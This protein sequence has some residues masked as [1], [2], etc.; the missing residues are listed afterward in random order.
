[1]SH[2]QPLK[3]DYSLAT[4]P[5]HRLKPQS[6]HVP[7]DSRLSMPESFTAIKTWQF[8][9]SDRIYWKLTVTFVLLLLIATSH[10]AK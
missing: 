6:H 10:V 7:I 2:P 1:M 5:V 4:P 3:D 8:K 9:A